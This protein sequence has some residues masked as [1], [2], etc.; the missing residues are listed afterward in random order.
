MRDFYL[1]KRQADRFSK[2]FFLILLGLLLYAKSL[3]PGLLFAIGISIALRQYLMGK[4]LDCLITTAFFG[5]LGFIVLI[6]MAFS[7]LFP[8]IFI[9]VGLYLVL[10]GSSY[11]GIIRLQ[12]RSSRSTEYKEF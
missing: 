10:K 8:F 5:F 7:F 4:R 6:G 9:G 1:S 2:G 12:Q 11:R 3:W